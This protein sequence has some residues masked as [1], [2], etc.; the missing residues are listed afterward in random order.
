MTFSHENS[1]LLGY[2][3]TLQWH[4][5]GEGG[6]NP[7]PPRN[8]KVL[9][10]LSRIP[11]SVENTSITTGF[12]HL[13]IEQNP[14]RGLPPLDPRS[15]CPVSSTELVEPLPSKKNSWVHHWHTHW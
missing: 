7:P 3:S 10:K 14:S 5:E 11:S 13:Q 9:T 6:F 12:T 2:Y 1:Q 8:S 15:L 4:T